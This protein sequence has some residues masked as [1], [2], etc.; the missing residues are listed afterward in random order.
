MATVL[1]RG[2]SISYQEQGSGPAIVLGHSFLCTGTMWRH[3][4][5]VL[6]EGYRV[7]NLD[8]RGHGGSGEVAG[9]FSLYDAVGDVLAVLDH[10]GID[11]AVWC[12]LSI[13]GMVALRAA[14]SA[15]ERVRALALFDTDAGVESG[16]KV[17]K[18]RAM[19]LVAGTIGIGPLLSPIAKLM[20]GPTTLREQPELVADWKKSAS[21]L[22]VPSVLRGLD[23][24]I[25]RDSLLSRLSE[26]RVP[27]LVVVGEEDRSLPVPHSL[28]IHRGI[29]DSR[30]VRVPAA[31]HLAALEQ[32]EPSNQA[33]L[34]FLSSLPRD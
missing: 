1:H 20:F 19:G 25:R 21:A 6:A 3:Q 26:I 31:G 4:V 14:L 27:S 28:A 5:P 22:H 32:P 30:L 23:T 9:S 33:L 34:G 17:L 18:Y 24:L 16:W 8:F 7:I 13:G 11:R 15:P 12:G 2:Q 10:L 29:V